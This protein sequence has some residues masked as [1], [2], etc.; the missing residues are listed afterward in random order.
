M[1]GFFIADCSTRFWKAWPSHKMVMNV[2]VLRSHLHSSSI[3]ESQKALFDDIEGVLASERNDDC[4]VFS[5]CM[6]RVV[7][8]SAQRLKVMDPGDVRLSD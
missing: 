3:Y 8:K 2:K 6:T 1:W 7:K 5:N 4:T